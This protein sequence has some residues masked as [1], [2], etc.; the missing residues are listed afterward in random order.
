[1]YTRKNIIEE[2]KKIIGIVPVIDMKHF[3]ELLLADLASKSP[4]IDCNNENTKTAYLSTDYKQIIQDIMYNEEF[5]NKFIEI[6]N[7]YT[8]YEYQLAWEQKLGNTLKKYLIE[9]K[10]EFNYDFERDCITVN[11]T[12]EEIENIKSKYDQ[13]TLN[14][15]CF[16]TNL[17][18][19]HLFSRIQNIELKDIKRN[20]KRHEHHL[21]DLKLRVKYSEK[22]GIQLAKQLK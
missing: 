19:A 9:S 18:S 8:Y 10:K 2:Q 20:I 4:I 16:F 14:D 15:M 17:M 1:M 12:E 5:G 6:I 21:K 11:F 13:K 22:V 3:V 7:I